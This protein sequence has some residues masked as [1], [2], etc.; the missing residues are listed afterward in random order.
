M[1]KSTVL[2]ALCGLFFMGA[3]SATNVTLYYSPTCPHCH[4]A[5]DF[6]GGQLVYEYPDITVEAVN[7]LEGDNRPEFE[8]TL[9]KCEFEFGGVPVIVVNDKCFQG[10][11]PGMDEDFRKA[12]DDKLSDTEKTAAAANRTELSSNPDQF[13]SKYANR[14]S[15]IVERVGTASADSQKKNSDDA[16]NNVIYFYILLAILV[17]GL[18]FVVLRKGNKK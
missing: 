9:K 10:Y 3:A 16:G 13:K 2:M 12:L 1:K 6:I 11:G 7:V 5:R 14:A 8:A 15:A 18:G 17:V 4:H